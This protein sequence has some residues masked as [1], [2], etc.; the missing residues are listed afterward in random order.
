[1]TDKLVTIASFSTPLEANMARL[2]LE[3]AGIPAFV[4]DEYT[5]GMNWLYSNALGGVK[6]QV[7][8]SMISE[9]QEIMASQAE[10]QT[11]DELATADAC[12][13]CGCKNTENFLDKRGS[14]ITWIL[15]GIPLLLP[16][17]KKKCCDCGHNW[18]LPQPKKC[19]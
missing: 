10:Q 13:Q 11:S 2:K 16:S 12:P 6:L 17:A 4:A 15:F 8:E 18:K 14:F 5:I 3:S 9:A 1:M 7:P 19:T